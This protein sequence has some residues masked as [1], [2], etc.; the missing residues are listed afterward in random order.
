VLGFNLKTSVELVV[1]ATKTPN[2]RRFLLN[3]GESGSHHCG[4]KIQQ[5]TLHIQV[6]GVRSSVQL[7]FL[8][9]TALINPSGHG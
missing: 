4:A 9:L 7:R 8:G 3:F 5:K 1:K 6:L 2:V